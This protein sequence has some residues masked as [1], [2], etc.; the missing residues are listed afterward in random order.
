MIRILNY[1][2]PEWNIKEIL[3]YSGCREEQ[4]EIID[5]IN[6]CI[7]EID[8][9]L[10]YKVCFEE[11]SVSMFD[12]LKSKTLETALK[13]SK[14]AVIFGA[15]I[16][17]EMDRIIARYSKISPLKSLIFASIGAER[18]EALCDAFCKEFGLKPRVSA[19]YGDIPLDFQKDIFAYLDLPR[20]IGL[21]L[22]SSFIM[23]PSKSVTA[24]AAVTE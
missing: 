9:K 10:I 6:E 3:R 15:T 19:G 1:D 16:G 4:S 11:V 18:I 20:K 2:A 23:S 24:I 7:S 8:G 17:L 12:A 22:N 21:M 5:I 13:G 14:K